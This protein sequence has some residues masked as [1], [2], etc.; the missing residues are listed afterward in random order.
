MIIYQQNCKMK[1]TVNINLGGYAFVIEE[2]AYLTL[3]D[4]LDRIKS[5]LKDDAE[6]ISNDIEERIA[7]I[8]N[9]KCKT[10]QVVSL[11]MV[12]EAKKRIGNP[13]DI[14]SGNQEDTHKTS[15]TSKR[16]YRD[17]EKR[18]LGGVC[19][20]LGNY[21]SVD[22]AFLR[23][24]FVVFFILGLMTR[25]EVFALISMLGYVILWIA[26]PAARTVE[27]KCEMK[28]K[29]MKLENFISSM[30]TEQFKKEVSDLG[31]SPAVKKTGRIMSGIIGVIIMIVGFGGLMG[32]F[33]IPMVPEIF[34]RHVN[35][36]DFIFG[37]PLAIA[38][39]IIYDDVFWWIVTAMVSL[40]S[41][42]FLYNG[43][44]LAFNFKSPSWKP[45]LILFLAWVVSILCIA[46]WSV[47]I[48][49]GMLPLIL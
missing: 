43:A 16:M 40:L 18:V 46:A 22:P 5:S 8:L 13:K 45:G 29:P 38:S 23:I 28:G 15:S 24:L 25:M 1:Q 41:I 2:D 39:R 21:L 17:M 34:S 20:G 37:T 14:S 12:E 49:S 9:E 4:Y 35:L 10:S 32:C 44:L 31:N 3:S 11:S 30:N 26:M 27:E 33:V 19:S 36:G 6:E 42:W 48:V 47:K 7:E